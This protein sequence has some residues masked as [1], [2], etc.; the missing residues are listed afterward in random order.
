[1]AIEDNANETTGG[2]LNDGQFAVPLSSGR[3]Q[4]TYNGLPGGTYQVFARYGGDGQ[5]GASASSPI[6]VTITPEASTTSLAI[7]A[8]NGLTG[9]SISPASIPYGSSVFSD[10]QITGSAEGANTQGVATG[11]VTF[12]EGTTTL[13]VL[14]VASQNEASWPPE[15]ASLPYFPGGSHSIVASYSGDPS[16]NASASRAKSFTIVPQA[17]SISTQ[18]IPTVVVEA[19][20]SSVFVTIGNLGNLGALPTGTVTLTANNQVIATIQNL[21]A[22]IQTYQG[23]KSAALTGYAMI[24]GSQLAVGLNTITATYSGDGNYAPS[25]TTFTLDLVATGGGFSM[26]AINPINAVSSASFGGPTTATLTLTSSGGYSGFLIFN[27]LITPQTFASCYVPETFIPAAGSVD[28]PLLIDTGQALAPGTYT[29]ALTGSDLSDPDIQAATNI[30]LVVTAAD[31]PS[32]AVLSGGGITV[33]PGGVPRMSFVSVLQSGGLTGQVNLSC[34]VSTAL[35]N[36]NGM[37]TCSVPASV[38]LNGAVPTIAGL[39]VNTSAGT[40]PGAYTASVTATSATSSTVTTTDRL[41]INVTSAPAF[42]LSSINSLSVPA[43]ALADNSATLTV[44]P[45]N[46]FAGTVNLGCYAAQDF[47]IATGSSLN[48]DV[49]SSVTLSGSSPVSVLMTVAT[50]V[51]TSPVWYSLQVDGTSTGTPAL[52]AESALELTIGAP[53]SLLSLSNAGNI[54]MGAGSTSGNTTSITIAPGGGFTGTV[55]LTCAVSTSPAGSQD[56]PTC[57]LSPSTVNIASTSAVTSIMTINTTAPTSARLRP[58]VTR[59]FI[60][61]M[62]TALAIILWFGFP[63]QFKN[64]NA[65]RAMILLVVIAVLA[66]G[67]CTRGAGGGGGGGG[68]TGTTPGTYGLIVIGTDTANNTI[69]ART[70]VTV[71][72]Q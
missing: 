65:F 66:C 21:N 4:G 23:V 33:A 41:P 36:A 60:G 15:N 39:Q 40:T 32:L 5:H 13:G 35:S 7:N 22:Q 14:P 52:S 29:I 50:S 28:A 16:F 64:R 63:A 61:G 18:E 10:V 2:N 44:T 55:S 9:A 53:V 27:C 19:G 26:T 71:T 24:Q 8:Y 58:S 30:N 11:T 37:P 70:S 67:G 59:S 48:C 12:T 17:T 51:N 49:P 43:G 45:L 25:S 68:S 57:S 47:D 3:G 56:P 20:A 42:V 46:G 34:S 1:V 54:Q 6:Q 31:A 69:S 62:E 72:I 38:T